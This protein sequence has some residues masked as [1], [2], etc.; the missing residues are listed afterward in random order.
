[1]RRSARRVA[2]AA[3]AATAVSLGLTAFSLASAS[4]PATQAKAVTPPCPEGSIC[5]YDE[6]NFTRELLT[7]TDRVIEQL[8]QSAD[9]RT[10][11]IINNTELELFLF[12]DAFSV[13]PVGRVA[14]HQKWVAPADADNQITSMYLY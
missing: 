8:P 4:T 14:A 12:K 7:T 3:V 1:M 5:L 11:S 2:A 10:S 9:N 13:G 6:N